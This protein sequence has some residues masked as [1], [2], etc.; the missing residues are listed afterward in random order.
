MNNNFMR[1]VY[2]ALLGVLP[3][4]IVHFYPVVDWVSGPFYTYFI[5]IPLLG[6]ELMLFLI[7]WL[8]KKHELLKRVQIFITAILFLIMGYYLYVH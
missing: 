8:L 5:M 4:L 2:L 3:I 7:F 1:H 6:I